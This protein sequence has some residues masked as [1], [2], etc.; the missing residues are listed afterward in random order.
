MFVLIITEASERG[1]FLEVGFSKV[2]IECF[3]ILIGA[4]KVKISDRDSDMF[5]CCCFNRISQNCFSFVF[6]VALAR[7]YSFGVTD[8]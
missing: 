5:L 3:I 7:C 6:S 4:N 2:K 1:V 8:N